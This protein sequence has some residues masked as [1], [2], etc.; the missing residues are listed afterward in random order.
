MIHCSWSY[1]N[2]IYN[3]QSA[4]P[5]SK[6]TRRHSF[7]ASR[8]SL[9][10][11]Y[12]LHINKWNSHV[13]LVAPEGWGCLIPLATRQFGQQTNI[14]H[15]WRNFY[16]GKFFVS[17]VFVYRHKFT[18]NWNMISWLCNYVNF[19]QERA[20]EFW[21]FVVVFRRDVDHACLFG[22]LVGP[23]GKWGRLKGI[24]IWFSSNRNEIV[25]W[26]YCVLIL[27]NNITWALLSCQDNFLNKHQVFF[28]SFVCYAIKRE[29]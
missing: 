16:G 7:Y 18:E 27:P 19:H 6:K 28:D 25:S 12:L 4:S 21:N 8:V 3:K 23:Y 2:L 13:K 10:M 17:I 20:L 15:G 1:Y 26:T 24:L 14:C 22:W 9:T 11:S 29:Q 5:G